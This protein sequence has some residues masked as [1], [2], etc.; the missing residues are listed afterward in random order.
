MSFRIILAAIWTILLDLSTVLGQKKKTLVSRNAGD[1][2]NLHP[3][4]RKAIFL[5][6]FSD[7][8][9]LL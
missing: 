4:G 1:K 2:K 7:I 5:I 6:N 9:F 3:G 8:S